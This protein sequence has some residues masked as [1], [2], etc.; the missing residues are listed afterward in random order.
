MNQQHLPLA[1]HFGY[2][3]LLRYTFP[4]IVMMVITSVYT[5]VDGFFVSNFVGKISFAAVNFVFPVIMIL[6][7]VGFMFGTGG[8]ALIAKTLGEGNH[9]RANRLFS[10]VVFAALLCGVILAAAALVFLRPLLALL[11]AQ[12]Q[13]LHDSVVYGTILLL[14]LPFFILQ[15]EFQCLFATAGKPKLGLV[16]TVAAGLTNMALDAL[17]VV[18]LR[19]GLAGAAG[20]T[21]FSQLVGGLIPVLYFARP[22]RSWLLLGRFVPERKALAVVCTNGASELLSNISSSLVS[23]LFN[24]QLIRYAG[25]NGVAA[26]GVLMYVSMIFQS[27]FLGYSVGVAPVIGY[28]YGA[29]NRQELRSLRKKSLRLITVFSLGMFSFSQL[30]ARPLALIFVSY[31]PELLAMTIHALVLFSTSFLLCGIGIFGSAFFTALNDGFTSALISF[32]RILV[33]QCLAVLLLPQLWGL[34]GI[35]LSVTA[36]EI[37]AAVLT[38]LLIFFKKKRFGY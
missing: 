29:Q 4:A 34:D 38:G 10:L 3:R 31:D 27:V 9:E 22:N 8:G 23:L 26:Y 25:E 13:L 37:L 11:G 28:Q 36:A 1:Q 16:V 35:W 24:L 19:W 21:A 30:L 32:L 6:G 5:V 12:G 17:F 15:Y 14:A 20:A 18:G 7:S 2:G 33:F